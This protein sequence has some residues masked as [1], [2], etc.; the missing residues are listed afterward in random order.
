[1]MRA[2]T[3]SNIALVHEFFHT[4]GGAERV[5]QSMR[6]LFPDAPLYVLTGAERLLR[7]TPWTTNARRAPLL[8]N[9]PN[10]LH[11]RPHLL[12]PLLPLA[13]ESIDLRDYDVIL[14]SSNSFAKGVITR[15]SSLH[16]CYCHSP[17]RYTWD[18]YHETLRTHRIAKPLLVPT[19]LALRLWDYQAAQRVDVFIA[20][21]KTTKERIKKFYGRDSTVI[22]PP[23]ETD[24]LTPT[25]NPDGPYIVI[26]R[27]S[28][29]KRIMNIIEAANTLRAPLEIIG[30]G[31]EERRLKR[32]AG[33][34]V[35]LRGRISD[36]DRNRALE[37]ARALIVASD[38]DFGI[39]P[40]EALA[41]GTPVIALRRGGL[42]ETVTENETGLFFNE[43]TTE[44]IVNAMRL[45]ET[46]KSSFS[47]QIMRNRAQHFSSQRFTHELR[48]FL[49]NNGERRNREHDTGSPRMGE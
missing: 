43:P 6:R 33:P 46:K 3:T 10:A 15:A 38:E 1:M 37:H 47:L 17:T 4:I 5:L 20:N 26:S 39:T 23:V 12:L 24:T 35:V 44:R 34:T 8:R 40:V 13:A 19:L 45:F 21:S 14:S 28:Q 31:R 27:L 48:T 32:A 29:Y 16:I 7:Q 2:K 42:M 18:W 36:T 30:T 22:Y 25:K 41:A 49:E 9:L 11:R